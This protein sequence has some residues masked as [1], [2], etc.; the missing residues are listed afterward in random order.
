MKKADEILDDEDLID[1][2]HEAVC[3][4]PADSY[5]CSESVPRTAGLIPFPAGA[6]Q[7]R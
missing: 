1:I 6:L 5:V 7:P 2:V 3:R 4:H